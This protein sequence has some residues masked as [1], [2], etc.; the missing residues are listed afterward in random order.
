MDEPGA[1]EQKVQQ[2]SKQSYDL[3]ADALLAACSKSPRLP[4]HISADRDVLFAPPSRLHSDHLVNIFFQEWAPLFPVLHRSTFLA[5]YV[6][7]MS[8]PASMLDKK[9]LAQLNLVFGIAALSIEVFGHCR[10]SSDKV[11]SSR[12]HRTK[13]HLSSFRVRGSGQ[14]LLTRSSRS[15]L[16]SLSSVLFLRRSLA[17]KLGIMTDS[18]ITKVFQSRS[19]IALDFTYPR[20][21]SRWEC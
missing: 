18:C 17:F 21:T 9:S 11:C 16:S 19:S 2:S 12:N 13:C 3:E 15:T 6:K 10:D 14:R 4:P 7:Y 20:S 8:K 1:F 5:L